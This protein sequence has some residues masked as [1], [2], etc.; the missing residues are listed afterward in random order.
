MV[1]VVRIQTPGA[2]DMKILIVG[3]EASWMGIH[4]HQFAAGFKQIGH[5]VR[6]A[7]YRKMEQSWA[8]FGLPKSMLERRR[9]RTLEK[10]LSQFQPDLTIFIT[11]RPRFNFAAIREYYNALIVVYDFDGPGWKC[12]E[13][14]DWIEQ[15]DLL[16]SV[17]RI[18]QRKLQERG[19]QCAYLP[20]GVDIDYYQPIQLEASE[21]AFYASPISFVGRPT[22]RRIKLLEGISDLDLILWGR[23]W[24]KKRDCPSPLLRTLARSSQDVIGKEVVKIYAA[25]NL[26]VN[27]LREPLHD[28]P[29]I[30]NLQAFSVPS[31][32]TC[33]L[34]EWVEELEEAFEP[35][36]ELLSFRT[37]QELKELVKKFHRD[38]AAAQTIGQAGRKRCEAQHTQTKRANQLLA[39]LS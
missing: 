14:L 39:F 2:D 19:I 29:T 25:A 1:Q 3:S 34:T 37:K 18:S 38:K 9:H 16:C 30:L 7:D 20:H 32:G 8:P 33:L 26:F 5:H 22:P 35:G 27:I 4:L 12:Y 6:L 15:I 11:A 13:S 28:P 36:K 21:S 17:S 31:T 10:I 23:R 24:S